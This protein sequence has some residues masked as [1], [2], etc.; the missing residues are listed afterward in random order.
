[1]SSHSLNR[2]SL[3][4]ERQA[5]LE[6]V[7]HF[8]EQWRQFPA[9]RDHVNRLE[10]D[11]AKIALATMAASVRPP[12]GEPIKADDSF[13]WHKCVEL[14]DNVFVCYRQIG[15]GIEFAVIERFP[16]GTNE[17]WNKGRNAVDVL[18][19]FTYDQQHALKIWTEDMTAQ[20]KE[21]LAEKFPDHDLTHVTESF[22]NRFTQAE[23]RNH[24]QQP[25]REI[26]I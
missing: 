11:I 15:N 3:E 1:M 26:R 19:A 16:T 14:F 4:I 10:C 25:N 23:L 22:L 24:P 20:V 9:T 2:R 18:K 6:I 12:H 13:F 17:I 7:Q 8:A 21:F 5:H